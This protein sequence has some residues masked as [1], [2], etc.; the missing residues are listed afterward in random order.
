MNEQNA[1]QSGNGGFASTL[2]F[3][4]EQFGGNI[5]NMVFVGWVL[6]FYTDDIIHEKP[7]VSMYLMGIILI[8]GR[9]VDAIADPI[10]GYWSD[11]TR[12]R[13][14]RRR[15]FIL[16]GTPFLVGS[17]LLL[18]YPIF[19]A[20]S[21]AL[22][23]WTVVVMGVFWFSFTVVMVPYL[24]L[25]PEI[26][27]S[28]RQRVGLTTYMALAM[29][30]AT[31]YQGFVAPQMVDAKAWNLG[32]FNMALI[33]A[34]IAFVFIYITGIGLRE[35]PPA[36]ADA[37]KKEEEKYSF[38]QAFGWTFKNRA[39]VIYILASVAQYL[40]FASLTAS[41][42]FIVTRLMGK[43]EGFVSIIYA[44]MFPGIIASFFVVN[45]AARK[46]GKVILYKICLLLL[47]L[48][49]PLLFFI[50][51]VALPVDAAT[52][53]LIIM[54][55]LTLP[56][57]GNMVLPMAILADITDNDAE[58]T[59]HRREA[60]FFGMQG[61]LQKAATALSTGI[62]AFLFGYFG[63]SMTNHLGVNLLGPVAG[64]FGFIGFLIFLK[65]PLD[66]R[67]KPNGE[68]EKDRV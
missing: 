7:L 53:G 51:R 40:G 21:A 3:L 2:I 1:E 66:D 44:V 23:L 31:A 67:P 46:Y 39:F 32:F 37:E 57:T 12:T 49:M 10:T 52:A 54:L 11:R 50:G 35:K 45:L 56:V 25:I 4:C 19:P 29:M 41:I 24:A 65:F 20:G 5:L 55:L 30:L 48:F 47:A 68:R 42:P 8:G 59:G 9:V 33:S 22:A 38:F 28:S 63:Y 60:I 27:T 17:F 58:K 36:V 34:A 26:A 6:Y 18:F 14:G 62:Q 61:F 16:G 15:P 13:I 43:T 64:F